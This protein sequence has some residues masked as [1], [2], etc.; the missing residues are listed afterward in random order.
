METENTKK[1]YFATIEETEVDEEGKVVISEQQPIVQAEQKEAEVANVTEVAKEA[2]VEK[3]NELTNEA[4]PESAVDSFEESATTE[5]ED[6]EAIID[7]ATQNKPKY[8]N[9]SFAQKML[10]AD[11]VIQDRYDELKNYALRYKKIKARISKKFDS[12]NKGR[13]QFVKLS[14]AGKT[15]KL[16]LN[17]DIATT[18][19]KFHC[20]DMSEKK[21]YVTTPVLLR[22]K[23][24]RAVKYAKI[25]IDQCAA[26]YGLKENK[27]FVEVDAIALVEQA[28][29]P[30]AKKSN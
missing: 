21:T 12:F 28:A 15:L 11:E 14:V 22:V 23:S 29:A 8:V 9:K 6:A 2:A 25:L 5:T 13:L 27:K 30:K 19:P 26:L 3:E 18:D 4:E 20:K 1:K 7:S 17:M 24:G 10:I 16:Y